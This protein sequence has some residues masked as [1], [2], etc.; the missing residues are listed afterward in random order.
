MIHMKRLDDELLEMLKTSRHTLIQTEA[1]LAVMRKQVDKQINLIE[2][3]LKSRQRQ[4]LYRKRHNLDR[5]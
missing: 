5:D 2:R 3:R 1:A 4:Q